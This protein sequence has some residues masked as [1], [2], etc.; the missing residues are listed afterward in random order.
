MNEK[1]G[2]LNL[3]RSRNPTL[4]QWRRAVSQCQRTASLQTTV[5]LGTEE[6]QVRSLSR[7]RSPGRKTSFLIALDH[8]L[9][10]IVMDMHDDTTSFVYDEIKVGKVQTSHGSLVLVVSWTA[11]YRD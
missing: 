6:D 8:G 7:V 2:H 1:S 5:H 10:I 9:V 11:L 4:T 3:V